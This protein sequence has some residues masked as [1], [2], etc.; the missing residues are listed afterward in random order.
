M[1]LAWPIAL[2]G[3]LLGIIAVL[4]VVLIVLLVRNYLRDRSRMPTA[5][6]KAQG[7]AADNEA[8]SPAP[9]PVAAAPAPTQAPAPAQPLAPAPAGSPRP[10]AYLEQDTNGGPPQI[11]RL[12][13]PVTVIGRDPACDIRIDERFVSVSRR[14]AQIAREDD[15]YVLSDLGSGSGVYVN[16]ARIG[17]N[18]VR[19]GAVI[20]IGQDVQYTFHVNPTARLA[21]TVCAKCQAENHPS[22]KYCRTC[23][24]ALPQPGNSPLAGV[25]RAPA[26]TQALPAVGKFSPLADSELLQDDRYEIVRL[27]TGATA[28]THISCATKGVHSAA[29]YDRKEGKF[30]EACGAQLGRLFVLLEGSNCR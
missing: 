23:G 21:M 12:D 19:D 11:F 8:A 10:A 28:A 13:R 29:E 4:F 5:L 14:H 15:T 7:T 27:V 22:A 30:C 3:L 25:V 18:R 1:G 6:R 26:P 9:P 24:A 16:G 17:R 20:R 2:L